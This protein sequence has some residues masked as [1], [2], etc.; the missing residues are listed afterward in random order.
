MRLVKGDAQDG[1]GTG[2][3]RR[4]L[5]GARSLGR[6]GFFWGEGNGRKQSSRCSSGFLVSMFWSFAKTLLGYGSKATGNSAKSKDTFH[7]CIPPGPV[8]I[9]FWKVPRSPA[10]NFARVEAAQ[11]LAV[12]RRSLRVRL[13][14]R[15][16]TLKAEA[17]EVEDQKG[18]CWCQ[19]GS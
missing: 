1:R 15:L 17:A 11:I 14:V 8:L 7:S 9:K 6:A 10:S 18:V 3:R 12:C 13:C 19:K 5:P 4:W 2:R 16:C